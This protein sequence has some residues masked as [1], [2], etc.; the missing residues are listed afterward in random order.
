MKTPRDL[1]EYNFDTA[2]KLKVPGDWNTQEE[3]LY[4]YEGT[5]WYQKYFDIEKRA[6]QKY[7]IEF[8]AVNY[9]AIVYINGEKIG[10]HEGGFTSF[11]FDITDHI[12]SGENF[13]VVKV[14]NAR[15]RDQVPTVNT[16]WAALVTRS[17]KAI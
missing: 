2:P 10:E 17:A 6:D 14:D 3:K 15:A 8:G 7:I 4:Y 13:V 5:V 9:H 16:D 1:I 12:D 11:Q